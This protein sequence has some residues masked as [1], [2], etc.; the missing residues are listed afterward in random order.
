MK[1]FTLAIHAVRHRV[2]AT[3]AA[4]ALAVSSLLVAQP[5]AADTTYPV[6]VTFDNVRFTMV[7]DGCIYHPFD[8]F[9]DTDTTLEVYGT[10]GAYTTAGA[11]SAAGGLAYRLFGKWG[12]DSCESYWDASYGTTCAKAMTLGLY[13]FTKVFLCGGSAYQT[14]STNYSKSNNTVPLQVHAGEQ[15]KVTVAMQDYDWGS[16]ND[17]VCNGYIWFGPYTAAEL[18]AKKF[19]TDSQ[20]K[21]ITSGYN[22]NAE[23]FVAFHLS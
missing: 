5:V 18:Q 9:C 17:N 14:C 1:T 2:A 8:F 23:C 16:A 4:L 15:F 10:V 6:N 21:K 20:G 22:G 3:A 19:V 12:T 7:N 13:D 11:S